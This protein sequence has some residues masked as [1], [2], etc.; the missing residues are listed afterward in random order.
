[1]IPMMPTPKKGDR[2]SLK[3]EILKLNEQ[4]RVIATK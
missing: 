1:M 2:I 3:S 4:L